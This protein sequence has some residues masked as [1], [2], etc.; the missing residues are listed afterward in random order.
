MSCGLGWLMSGS[1]LLLLMW[2]G[3]QGTTLFL[4]GVIGLTL[5]PLHPF[6]YRWALRC[7][8]RPR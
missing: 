1:L 7:L 2:G 5:P 3:V 4:F 8:C 6:V